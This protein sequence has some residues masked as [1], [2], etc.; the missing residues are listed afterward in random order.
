M[1]TPRLTGRAAQIL[2]AVRELP[3]GAGAAT[4]RP[5]TGGHSHEC[6]R[7]T[8]P[9]GDL[10][11]KV[12]LR[13]RRPERVARHAAMHQAAYAAG[14]PVARL[15]TTVGNSLALDAPM[16]VL[17]WVEGTDAEAMWPQL[18]AADQAAVCRGWGA[19]VL[20]SR[21][22]SSGCMVLGVQWLPRAV[23]AG[24]GR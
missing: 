15:L 14:V 13:D 2:A 3:G 17:S 9:G 24:V 23:S 5:V 18:A 19:I 7:L 1:P 6:W 21:S 11:V 10:L 22:P 16:L 20:A 8:S 4:P 12:P